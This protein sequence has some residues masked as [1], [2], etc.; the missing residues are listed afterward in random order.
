MHIHKIK[1]GDKVK[2]LLRVSYRDGGT[3]KK[4][5]LA[6]L[7]SWSQDD[8]IELERLLKAKRAASGKDLHKELGIRIFGFVASLTPSAKL[9]KLL[10]LPMVLKDRSAEN[11]WERGHASARKSR[12]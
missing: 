6:N 9:W 5:T 8:L 12:G 1:S 7:S 11:I 2:L 3:V 4:F 10:N